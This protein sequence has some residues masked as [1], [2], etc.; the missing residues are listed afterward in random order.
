M[1]GATALGTVALTSPVLP[2]ST[3]WWSPSHEANPSQQVDRLLAGAEEWTDASAA[4]R[5]LWEASLLAATDLGDPERAITLL[6]RLLKTHPASVHTT[7]A[8]A[9]RATLLSKTGAAEAAFAYQTAAEHAPEHPEAGRWW[10]DAA[11]HYI[12]LGQTLPAVE[13]YEAATRH[14]PRAAVAWLALGRLRLAHDPAAAHAAFEA[15]GQAAQRPTTARLARLGAATALER[16]E[17]PEAALAEVDDAIAQEGSDP[18][19]ERRRDR[20]RNGG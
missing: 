3:A 19:L 15:A 2:I 13:A 16:L 11:D 1:W 10:L 17:G 8:L 18:S 7:D 4:A 12:E 14:P 20:L 5:A 6:D 9:W